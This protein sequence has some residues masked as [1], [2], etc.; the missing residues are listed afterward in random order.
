[1]S[2]TR[3]ATVAWIIALS[4]VRVVMS[5]IAMAVSIYFMSPAE[6]EMLESFRRGWVRSTGF[7]VEE[8]GPEQ[9]GEVAGTALIP[10]V[11]SVLILQFVRRRKL[12]ALR[13]AAVVNFVMSVT[14]PLTWLITLTTVILASRQSTRD[15]MEGVKPAPAARPAR[16]PARASGRPA[17]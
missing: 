12:K 13:V 3:P 5:V 11:L 8:Y 7:T 16:A 17:A 15:Y 14:Q 10:L 1:M 4:R 6:S 2:S 9:A